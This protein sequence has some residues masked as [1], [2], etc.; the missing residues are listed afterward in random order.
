MK[1]KNIQVKNYRTIEDIDIAFPA[2]YSAICG[3]N[4]SGKTNLI[5][6]IRHVLDRNDN[7][8]MGEDLSINWKNDFPKWKIKNASNEDISISLCMT[9]DPKNDAAVYK[10]IE[11]FTSS[12]NEKPVDSNTETDFHITLRYSENS[13]PKIG[14]DFAGKKID[15][16]YKIAEILK[17]IKNSNCLLFHNSTESLSKLKFLRDYSSYFN[18]SS[19]EDRQESPFGEMG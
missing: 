15:D 19:K 12:E 10:F 14:M 17:K 18:I 2:F 9:L 5:R 8:L 4:D 7:F 11:T 16:E 3:K 1:I 6:I 13:K